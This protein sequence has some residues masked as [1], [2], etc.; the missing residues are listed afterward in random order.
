M[1]LK[2]PRSFL[3]NFNCSVFYSQSYYFSFCIHWN[4]ASE[5]ISDGFKSNVFCWKICALWI[6]EIKNK[7]YK[8]YAIPLLVVIF[9]GYNVLLTLNL[10][11][12]PRNLEKFIPELIFYFCEVQNVFKVYVVTIKSKQIKEVF[13][14]LD[15]DIFIGDTQEHKAIT[16]SYKF[17]YIKCF[18]I[19][20]VMCH[21]AYIHVA[22]PF[23][24]H[25]ILG[26]NLDLPI[27]NYYFLSDEFRENSF[28]LIWWYQAVS[29]YFHMFYNITIDT[30][31]SGL[32]LMGIAQFK[33]L[34]SS[35]INIKETS[36]DHLNCMEKDDH[37][38]K[39]LL[40]CLKH[41]DL[42]LQ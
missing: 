8:Y 41:Y 6:F 31:I 19:Y 25:L 4:M 21:M 22:L 35:L 10:I 36:L 29:S 24:I 42:L 23:L 18:N 40:K 37:L 34:N 9:V 5:K 13:N 1:N 2:W 28:W 11:Y 26:K 14:L 33:A 20:C 38:Q 15:S 39:Q 27:C 7:Y 32:L 30:F 17:L 12:T 16:Q 3:S